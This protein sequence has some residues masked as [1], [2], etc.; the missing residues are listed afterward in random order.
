MTDTEKYI[1]D[2]ATREVEHCR[3]WPTRV[4]AFFFAINFGLVAGLAALLNTSLRTQMPI[5]M[6]GKYVLILALLLLAI[7]VVGILIRNHRIYLKYREL[8]VSTQSS[9][10]PP[11]PAREGL[12]PEWFTEARSSS[13]DR[14]WGYGLYVYMV[15]LVTL[16]T[17]AAVQ[18]MINP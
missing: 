4:M 11:G 2:Q 12:P 17:I 1:L 10:F 5:S 9:V 3:T 6:G 7:W 16:L 18:G 8:Q 15:L 14:Y 13:L